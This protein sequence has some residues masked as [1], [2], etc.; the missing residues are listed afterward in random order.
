MSAHVI[1]QIPS[2]VTRDQQTWRKEYKGEKSAVVA[3]SATPAAA[4]PAKKFASKPAKTMGPPKMEYQARGFKWV[5]ENQTKETA[6]GGL[7]VEV[8]DSKQQVYAYNCEGVTLQ[9]KGKVKSVVLDKCTKVALVFESCISSV[10]IVN[11]KRIQVQ[12][13]G[14][15]PTF[16]IDKTTGCL[17]W[18]SKESMAV[19]SFVASMSS[20]MNVSYPDEKSG[21]QKEVP[22]PEQFVHTLKDGSITSEVS[23]LYH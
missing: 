4:S 13:T 7:T 15:C 23:D 19:S 14:I 12:T 2:K 1:V 3:A 11:C 6:S 10:E 16:T 18:L 22:I 8:T 17:I 9:V 5:V 20:E 21:D